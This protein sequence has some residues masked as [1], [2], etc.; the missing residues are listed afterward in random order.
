MQQ[1]KCH[2]FQKFCLQWTQRQTHPT[3]CSIRTTKAVSK[4]LYRRRILLLG[5]NGRR[6]HGSLRNESRMSFRKGDVNKALVDAL[7]TDGM[8]SS[9]CVQALVVSS[10]D[11]LLCMTMKCY[12]PFT[13]TLGC[14]SCVFTSGAQQRA[15]YVRTT[16]NYVS[17]KNSLRLFSLDHTHQVTSYHGRLWY[18]KYLTGLFKK[19]KSNQTRCRVKPNVSPPGCAISRLCPATPVR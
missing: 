9:M 16:F 18:I 15:A 14:A 19:I 11:C 3:D 5:Y 8:I 13:H 2:L 6:R 12:G 4:Y 10:F 1:L 7:I 17:C